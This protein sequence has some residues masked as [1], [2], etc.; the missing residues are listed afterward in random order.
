MKEMFSYTQH[1]GSRYV[2]HYWNLIQVAIFTIA[3]FWFGSWSIDKKNFQHVFQYA[4][5]KYF[6]S[7]R[8]ACYT[9]FLLL[10][11]FWLNIIDG[12]QHWYR[13]LLILILS[14]CRVIFRD[15]NAVVCSFSPSICHEWDFHCHREHL[16]LVFFLVNNNIKK[17]RYKIFRSHIDDEYVIYGTCGMFY[18]CYF[19]DGYTTAC[20]IHNVAAS[21][22]RFF[23]FIFL[24]IKA[25][26]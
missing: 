21:N 24:W 17:I 1:S 2:W 7:Y 3:F 20:S 4:S 22:K 16:L 13:L 15:V 11:V 5:L 10:L 26:K 9:V 18:T 23:S 8:A 6:F 25:E 12:S 14:V 19:D